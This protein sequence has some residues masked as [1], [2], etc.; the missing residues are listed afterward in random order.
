[1]KIVLIGSGNIAT[2]LGKAFS[3]AGHQIVQVYSKTLA[4]ADALANV[5]D[6]EAIDNLNQI[7]LDSDL[8][9]VAVT[10]SAISHVADAIPKNLKG[11]V[12]HCS[13]ATDISVLK[14]F[15][16]HGVIYP[17]QSF[18]KDKKLDLSHTPF[19]IET[20][21]E[22]NYD[23]LL[24]LA[25]QVSDYVFKCNTKQRLALHISA[26]FANNFSNALF[27]IS[28]DLLEE[29]ELSFDLIRPIILETAEKVQ[30]HIPKDVQT[31]PA[32]R[33]DNSTMLTHFN[34]ISSHPD[35]QLIYQK[36]SDL[37][38]KTRENKTEN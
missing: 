2:H 16:Q 29:H 30:N 8:Y 31:G 1:M 34:F 22:L 7:D 36:I 15:N 9:L 13:G 14:D 35:W 37:I 19:G 21:T 18:S 12:A 32:L 5:L 4:N 24:G 11:I 20:N 38:I 33:N 10:D 3:D 17:V 25:G 27:Q 23:I 26:V 6:S 28:Y